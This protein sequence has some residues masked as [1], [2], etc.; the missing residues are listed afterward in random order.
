VCKTLHQ[1]A[2]CSL[3]ECIV[4][5]CR[6]NLAQSMDLQGHVA[7]GIDSQQAVDTIAVVVAEVFARGQPVQCLQAILATDGA[8]W[9]LSPAFEKHDMM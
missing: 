8:L 9:L 2:G 7:C 6:A 5:V 4:K 1:L 3:A